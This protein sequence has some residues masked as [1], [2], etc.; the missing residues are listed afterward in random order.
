MTNPADIRTIFGSNLKKLSVGYPSITY[1]AQELGINRTQFN[2][3]LSGESFPRPDILDRMCK[4]F[5]VDARVLLEPLEE[6]KKV[7]PTPPDFMGDFIVSGALDL[8]EATFPSGFYRFSRRSF[9]DPDMFAVGLVMVFRRARNTYLKGYETTQ[10]MRIQSLPAK[11]EL[12]EFRG[13]VLM[14]EEGIAI[15][16]SRRGAMTS[17]FNYLGRIAS[18]NNNFWVG[19]ITR[20]VPEN[21]IGLRATRLVYEYLPQTPSAVLKAARGKGFYSKEELEPFHRRLLRTENAFE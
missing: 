3:Y 2:R 21:S 4:F 16:A 8:P 10:A 5:D 12:R 11:P 6:I 1:L 9:L 15:I 18:F 20:T 19:Y 17:S 14:Q 13:V 7:E